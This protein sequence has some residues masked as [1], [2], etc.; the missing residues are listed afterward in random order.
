[1]SMLRLAW[2]GLV[3]ACLA[4]ATA[5]AQAPEPTYPSQMV[6]VIVPFSPGSVTDI[7]ARTI[8]ERLAEA[9]KEPVIVDN[10]PGI[11]GTASAAK[12]APDG[13]TLLVTSNGHAVIGSLNR[14]LGFDPVKDFAGV[15]QLAS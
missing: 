6:R 13:L 2:L 4:D 10:R 12:A 3:A 1:M 7:L 11:P 14:N 9:W 5:S 8:A 15:T